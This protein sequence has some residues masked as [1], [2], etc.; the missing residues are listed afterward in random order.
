MKSTDEIHHLIHEI[1][2]NESQ[3]DFRE[4]YTYYFNTLM[5][6][7]MIYVPNQYDAEEIVSDAFLPQAIV[8]GKQIGRAH[9]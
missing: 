4:L 1:A 2:I 6:F 3:R 7:S 5:R 9:V 8:T